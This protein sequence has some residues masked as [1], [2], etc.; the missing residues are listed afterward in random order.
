MTA[1]AD[2]P[3]A[4][5]APTKVTATSAR[6]NGLPALDT[7]GV[8]FRVAPPKRTRSARLHAPS[9]TACR[10]QSPGSVLGSRYS[11][12]ANAPR[13]PDPDRGRAAPGR[14]QLG[15]AVHLQGP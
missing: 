9:G 4:G 7:K 10:R 5:A 6:S 1:P 13:S 11:P 8:S 2:P 14:L 3:P 12:R 15:G